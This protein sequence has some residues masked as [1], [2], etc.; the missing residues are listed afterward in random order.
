MKKKG[1]ILIVFVVGLIFSWMLIPQDRADGVG[2]RAQQITTEERKLTEQK[3]KLADWVY[4]HS[5]K[6][7]KKI[8]RE[9]VDASYPYKNA[10]LLLAIFEME[11]NFV[12][13]AISRKGAR[14]LG[15][16]H[17]SSHEKVLAETGICKQERDLFDPETNVRAS[18]L[19]LVD[20]LDRSNGDV[21]KALRLYLGCHNGAYTMR[22][23]NNYVQLSMLTGT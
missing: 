10:L 21:I 13:S 17:W 20:M 22:V 8:A 2:A 1:L 11:S 23:L 18:N 15:Q 3:E 14:G 16:V 9:I 7:S 12:P 5:E 19:I 6:I 4:Q